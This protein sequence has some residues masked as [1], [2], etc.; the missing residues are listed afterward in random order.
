[1]ELD[2]NPNPIKDQHFMTDETIINKI[3]DI[4][5]VKPGDNVVEIGG[6]AG[7]LTKH[8]ASIGALITV[9]EKDTYYASY[10]K[11]M[12]KNN[13]NVTVIEG[14]A[15]NFNY[16]DYNKIVANMPYSITESFLFKLVNSKA[17]D[18]DKATLILPHGTIRKMLAPLSSGEFGLTSLISKVFFDLEVMGEVPREAFYPEPS[19]NSYIVNLKPKRDFSTINRLLSNMLIQGDIPIKSAFRN[20]INKENIYKTNKNRFSSTNIASVFFSDNK[21]GNKKFSQL[22][23]GDTT[24]LVEDAIKFDIY[25]KEK[26][27]RETQERDYRQVDWSIYLNRGNTR[28]SDIDDYD[29]KDDDENQYNNLLTSHQ[30]RGVKEKLLRQY[31]YFYYNPLYEVFENRHP[32][33]KEYLGIKLND[34]IKPRK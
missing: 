25:V 7:A 1:M 4:S 9:I 22:G 11:D 26:T 2:K 19:V 31:E 13:P 18:F 14:D 20:V 29:D 24:K 6:G 23:I 27:R 32:E 5:E 21:I 30:K 28:I 3:C 33:E 8:L 17:V 34:S 16:D 10:L 12:F 15:L